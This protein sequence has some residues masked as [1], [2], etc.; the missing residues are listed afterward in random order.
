MMLRELCWPDRKCPKPPPR[1]MH[2]RGKHWRGY[3]PPMEHAGGRPYTPNLQVR[4][5]IQAMIWTHWFVQHG[6]KI[7]SDGQSENSCALKGMKRRQLKKLGLLEHGMW[8]RK[9]N[10]SKSD[11]YLSFS[12]HWKENPCLFSKSIV[13]TLM[14]YKSLEIILIFPFDSLPIY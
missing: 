12:P 5:N 2:E 8:P 9:I 6:L 7:C 11:A 13:K 14:Y 1:R 10:N 3:D 4:F